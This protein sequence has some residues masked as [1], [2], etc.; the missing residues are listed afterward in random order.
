MS[1]DGNP[2]ISISLSRKINTGNY[3][4]ADVYVCLSGVPVGASEDE[5]QAMLETGSLA[6]TM[7]AANL[8]EK[9]AQVRENARRT[10]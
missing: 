9:V 4:S 10:A 3:E 1:A 2:T 5:I 8:K 7:I 6:Y